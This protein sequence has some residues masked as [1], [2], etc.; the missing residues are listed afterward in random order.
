[1][2]WKYSVYNKRNWQHRLF[3]FG[4]DA[5]KRDLPQPQAQFGPAI[6]SLLAAG[7]QAANAISRERPPVL[8]TGYAALAASTLLAA[9]IVTFCLAFP[10][11]GH[12][13]EH[14]ELNGW[15]EGL[16]RPYG[17]PCC[18]RRDCH[19]TDAEL[20]QDGWY[21]RLG[22]PVYS[23]A[24]QEVPEWRL[25]DPP[26]HIPENVIVK[27]SRGRPVNNPEGEAVICHQAALVNG[28]ADVDPAT[29]TVWC[30]VPPGE[31]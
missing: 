3:C 1:M 19:R 20:R 9:I 27:D 8:L 28:K 29:T 31:Y 7:L 25:I 11:V 18:S 12:E 30:F 22:M 13:R 5:P 24:G 21:A 17:L 16:R 26:V 15:Y 14:P 23:D 10:A 6:R 2:L 4:C